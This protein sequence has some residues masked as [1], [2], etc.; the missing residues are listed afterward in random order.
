[1]KIG[2]S[3]HRREMLLFLTLTHHQHGRRDVMCKP[4][5]GSKFCRHNFVKSKA[6]LKPWPNET[7]FKSN[8]NF[9]L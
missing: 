7:I 1:M 6:F 9:K 2:F 4:A 3:S 5:I 8:I